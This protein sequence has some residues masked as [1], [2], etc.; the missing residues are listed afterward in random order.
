MHQIL[1]IRGMQAIRQLQSKT[2]PQQLAVPTAPITHS[3]PRDVFQRLIS[4]LDT[5]GRYFF[6]N[7]VANQWRYPNNNTH[8][9]SCVLLYLFTE[10]N[11]GSIQE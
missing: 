4:D 9:F 2:T 8:Y 3:A 6:L 10:V 1:K 11:Q 7:T 5:E